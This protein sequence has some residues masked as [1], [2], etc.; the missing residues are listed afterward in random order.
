MT[1][2][3]KLSFAL[4]VAATTLAAAGGAEAGWPGH[5][6][7]LRLPYYAAYDQFWKLKN[8]GGPV[9]L[10]PQPLPPGRN[11]NSF[12]L[13]NPGADVDFNPQPDPP[14]YF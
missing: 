4:V 7:R 9:E 12:G 10:N 3:V 5:H 14:G 1:S 6:S 13:A 8:P 11:F 2:V